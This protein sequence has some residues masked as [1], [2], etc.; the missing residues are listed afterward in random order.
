MNHN[1]QNQPQEIIISPAV[2]DRAREIIYSTDGWEDLK[3]SMPWFFE[4]MEALPNTYKLLHRTGVF[5]RAMGLDAISRAQGLPDGTY[6]KI[7]RV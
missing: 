4:A 7:G 1:I 2:A 3:E 5:E 6:W